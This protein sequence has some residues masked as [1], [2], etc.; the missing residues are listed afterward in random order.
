[1]ATN[2]TVAHVENVG[3]TQHETFDGVDVAINARLADVTLTGGFATGNTSFDTCGS[4][5][6]NPAATFGLGAAANT[7]GTGTVFSYCKY[8]TSWLTQAKLTGSYVLPWQEIQLGAV[9]QNLPGQQILANW[10][11]TQA[12]V[13]ATGTLGRPLSGGANTSRT[14]P[15]IEPGTMYTP[16]RTQVD[17]RL[18]KTFKA[19]GSRRVQG[20]VDIFN[21]TNSNAA[22]GATSNAGEPPA[23]INTTFG[24]AW[25][26]PLNIL[27]ARYFK[28][29]VQ[30]NF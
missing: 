25:L 5:V 22:V 3:G 20:M 15:L 4:Y 26:K 21:L 23:A 2:N 29:G 19:G 28:F 6:D 7:P 16:R 9:V 13:A 1:M 14:V 30:F 27:Q 11:I 18:G 12:D 17:L 8:Q 10:A 24:G